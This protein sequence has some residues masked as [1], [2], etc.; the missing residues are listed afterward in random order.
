MQEEN[1]VL[2]YSTNNT[3]ITKHAFD[4]KSN[5]Y[6]HSN[7]SI[8]FMEAIQVKINTRMTEE[9]GAKEELQ[10][11]N[12]ETLLRRSTKVKL[13]YSPTQTTQPGFVDQILRKE[14]QQRS[15]KVV[16]AVTD[17]K[18]KSGDGLTLVAALWQIDTTN[19]VD[20]TAPELE[21]CAGRVGPRRRITSKIH[22]HS[23]HCK[24]AFRL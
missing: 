21:S 4:Y 19:V 24:M 22:V 11:W 9:W 20:L 23:V 18:S 2:R 5:S 16:N 10:G 6:M 13:K 12:T 14:R 17:D 7:S 1:T 8:A 3:V 15:D